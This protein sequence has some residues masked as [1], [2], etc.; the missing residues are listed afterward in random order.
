MS[1]DTD[2]RRL[3]LLASLKDLRTMS[4]EEYKRRFTEEAT[5]KRKTLDY[6]ELCLAYAKRLYEKQVPVIYDIKHLSLLVGIKE[7]YIRRAITYTNKFYWKFDVLK[8]NGGKRHINEPL[9][10]L[11]DI[12][13]WIL[14]N[15]LEKQ[16][17]HPCAKAYVPHRKLKENAKYHTRQ[18]VVVSFDVQNFFPS[19]NLEA[20]SNI[21]ISIGYSRKNAFLLAKLCCLDNELP[22]GAPTSPYLSNLYM[23]SFDE[24]IMRYCREVGIIYTRYADDITFSSKKDIDVDAL[25]E[26]VRNELSSK[27]LSLNPQKSKI[28]GRSD[29]QIVTGIVVN[30]RMRLPKDKRY[31]LRQEMY[32]IITKGV[33]DHVSFIECKKMNYLK[34]LAGKIRYALY[35]EP[36]NTEFQDYYTFLQRLMEPNFKRRKKNLI[37]ESNK[38][39]KEILTEQLS[40]DDIA[41]IK[42]DNGTREFGNFDLQNSSNWCHANP[43]LFA[44]LLIRKFPEA[45]VKISEGIVVMTNGF[46]YEHFWYHIIQKDSEHFYDVT[47]DCFEKKVFQVKDRRYYRVKEY[48][49]SELIQRMYVDMNFSESLD[50]LRLYYKKYPMYSELYHKLNKKLNKESDD[51]DSF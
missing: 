36:T 8:S 49:I 24:N 33:D 15:I 25:I 43:L 27:R 21:F 47:R 5:K 11:K 32:Y 41:Y 40:A 13:L 10:L 3:A 42:D 18:K 48:T 45:E 35:L 20:V 50:Y 23:L 2:V 30:E 38:P 26:F 1:D 28:M 12:Q 22:Q 34:H 16:K 39:L 44:N 46:A 6:I 9:P 31:K 37:L 4:F 14:H 51:M 29:A 19:I 17:T 7:D